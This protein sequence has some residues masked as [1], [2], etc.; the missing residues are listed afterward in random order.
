MMTDE[1]ITLARKG[2]NPMSEVKLLPSG[3]VSWVLDKILQEYNSRNIDGIV[4]GLKLKDGSFACSFST[5]GITY[6]EKLGLVSQLEDDIK[7]SVK[8]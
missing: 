3:S 2:G 7:S 5:E 1:R 6:L 4:V 8:D